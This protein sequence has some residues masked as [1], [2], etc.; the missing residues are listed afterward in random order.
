MIIS[1]ASGPFFNLTLPPLHIQYSYS[2]IR[3]G[4]DKAHVDAV[5]DR[6]DSFD[7]DS[8]NDSDTDTFDVSVR[9]AQ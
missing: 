1:W 2:N 4:F 6:R 3:E 8:D 9:S 7:V 5:T